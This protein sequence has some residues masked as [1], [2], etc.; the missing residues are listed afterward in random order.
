M[1]AAILPYSSG[2]VIV[3]P[4]S[5]TAG[6][7]GPLPLPKTPGSCCG[8]LRGGSE[9]RYENIFRVQTLFHSE[10]NF[11]GWRTTITISAQRKSNNII[12][13]RYSNELQLF[14]GY[15]MMPCIRASAFNTKSINKHMQIIMKN[16]LKGDLA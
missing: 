5:N 10:K 14:F 15:V 13:F 9:M 8:E 6:I 12:L 11:F 1:S 16:E 2:Y 4:G 7:G 3:F